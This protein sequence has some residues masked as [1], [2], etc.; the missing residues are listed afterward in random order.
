MK[1]I[2]YTHRN[3]ESFGALVGEQIV[4][5]KAAFEDRYTD[6]KAFLSANVLV[7]AKQYLDGCDSQ[8]SLADVTLLPPIPNPGTIWCVAFNTHSHFH[9]IKTRMKMDTLPSK[10]ALFIRSTQTLVASGDAIEKPK[11]EPIFD[12]EGEIALVIGQ[13]ARNVGVDRALDYIAGVSC[14]NDASARVY[15]M[16][17]NQVSAGKNAYRSGG[18]G[19]CLVTA[20]ELD[21]STMKMTCRLNGKPM[22]TM[23]LDDLIFGFSELVSYISEFTVLEPGDVIV[24]G[25]PEGIG[26]LRNPPV[27]LKS[28]DEIEV[29]VTGVGIL[30]NAVHEQQLD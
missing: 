3:Q 21:F 1:L 12:Y 26:V 6:L 2:S 7:E 18:F 11:L 19:P 29:E 30:R 9:E 10:P 22:Q 8:L 24:T 20:D 17:S 28:G 5:L 15:Q 25:S 16:H 4:D 13:R 27:H 23:T 14:F